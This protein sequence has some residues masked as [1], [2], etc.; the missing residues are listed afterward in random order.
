MNL[1][2]GGYWDGVNVFFIPEFREFRESEDRVLWV[3]LYLPL[4][5]HLAGLTLIP[6]SRTL[7][8][9]RVFLDIIKLK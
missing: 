7:F 2:F 3:S 4:N 6:H 9:D 5:L 8:G 1:E